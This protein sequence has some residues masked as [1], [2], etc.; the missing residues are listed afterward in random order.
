M[1][2]LFW[3]N[4][5]AHAI[6]IVIA[7][8]FGLMVLATKPKCTINQFFALFALAE[9]TWT[10]FSFLLRMML[11]LQVGNPVL[12]LE[13]ATLFFVLAGPFL[14]LFTARYVDSR[15]RWVDLAAALGLASLIP[16]SIP[17]SVTRSFSIP[18]GFRTTQ[19]RTTTSIPGDS[20]G[21]RCQPRTW[22]GP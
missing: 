5:A 21:P 7:T 18:A 17:S 8:A 4:C 16:L 13:L 14:L 6:S 1:S 10:A 19:P 9:A 3:L 15:A 11:W 22:C 20:W 2:L 12:M